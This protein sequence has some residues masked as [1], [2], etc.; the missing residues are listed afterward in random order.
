MLLSPDS[1]LSPL[2]PRRVQPNRRERQPWKSV[3]LSIASH[4]IVDRCDRQFVGWQLAK[5]ASTFVLK[6]DR[7]RRFVLSSRQRYD[8]SWALPPRS[9]AESAESARCPCCLTRLKTPLPLRPC[10]TTFGI[11]AKVVLTSTLPTYSHDIVRAARYQSYPKVCRLRP[12]LHAIRYVFVFSAS[13]AARIL[14]PGAA[15]PCFL[16]LPNH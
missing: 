8:T 5:Q 16:A 7:H 2:L 9:E 6:T 10:T 14:H 3:P 12:V 11:H 4:C 15:C 13:K 1:G